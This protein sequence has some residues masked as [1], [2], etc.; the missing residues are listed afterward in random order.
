LDAFVERE[1]EF[2]IQIPLKIFCGTWN[3]NGGKNLNNIAFKFGNNNNSLSSWI[4]PT[5]LCKRFIFLN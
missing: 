3:V 1:K 2:C 5:N 4:F